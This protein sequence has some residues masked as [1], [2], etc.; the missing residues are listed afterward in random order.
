MK[1]MK[2]A[3]KI[4]LIVVIAVSLILISTFTYLGVSERSKDLDYA[5]N[6]SASIARE[7]AAAI[8][9]EL[10]VTL[11]SARTLAQ[12]L[13]A[14]EEYPIESRRQICSSIIKKLADENKNF[15]G[16]W[17]CFEP[18]AL[19][20]MDNKFAN[21]EGH[22]QTGR[23]IPYW[24]RG[25]QGVSH[26]ALVDYA[27]E[28]SGD[29]YLLALRSG[30]ES[31]LE[32]YI[33]QISGKNVLLTTFSVP[34]KN[35]LGKII[36]V[37]GID[38]SLDTLN[39]MKF[40]AGNFTS[41]NV[42]LLS[43]SGT[44]VIH[45]NKE[46]LGKKL[47]D[48]E[49]DKNKIEK[50]LGA[51]KAGNS[52]VTEGTS[53]VTKAESLKTMV[54]IVLGN[55]GAPWSTGFTVKMSEITAKSNANII[56]LITIFILVIAAISAA[57]W[58]SVVRI[59]KRPLSQLV[60]VAEQQA[61]GNYDMD[62]NSDRGDE[63]G[64][65]FQSLK[66]VNDNMNVLVSNM[67]EASEQ[68]TS[69][70]KQ[71]S[72]SSIGLAQGATEQASTIEELTASIE[73]ISSQTNMN[74][75][76]A[77]EAN[78]LA[79]TAK[80]NAVNGNVQMQ[81]MLIAMNNINESSGNIFKIIKVIDEIAFQTNILALNA[82]VEAARAG[83]HGKGFAVVAEE[84]R[85]LAARSA[86]AAKE[87][88]AMIESSIKKV[89]DGTMIANE[90]AKALDKIV[91]DVSRVASLVSEIATASHE[92]SSG[93]NQINQGIIQVSNVVQ[94]NSATS[95]ESAAASEELLSQAEALKDQV[96]QFKLRQNR[97][98]FMI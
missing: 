71:I 77:R 34:I 69:G 29:Y 87:T 11:D 65:L 45:S 52:Y 93:I 54:P 23:F 64:I 62:I 84:V 1:K 37:A 68:V 72:T 96:S 25:E 28:G 86:N 61:K 89:K 39:S 36:G 97:N 66:A 2:L 88:T 78:T 20:G 4:I 15:L 98:G 95:E 40:N 27:V 83:Q 7:N 73:E 92:Q 21:S 30:K 82:A 33:Y 5:Y 6:N 76:N 8:K 12:T 18:N 44:Y 67:R 3:T 22:D 79:E 50:M 10:E 17:A 59:I 60:A 31:I 63:L 35:A 55:T 14:F 48:I 75:G 42:Y 19:D 16:A 51:I 9:A 94:T 90:T 70:A 53:E 91:E 43:N 85:N 13:S 74:A 47:S 80:T 58:I 24:S 26:S 32:P 46:T 56:L 41:A 57:I 49:L 81:E 38:I